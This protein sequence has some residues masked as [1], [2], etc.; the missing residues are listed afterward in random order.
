MVG[1]G[2]KKNVRESYANKVK[3]E[4]TKEGQFRHKLRRTSCSSTSVFTVRI[5]YEHAM[6][7]GQEHGD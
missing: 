5:Q 1:F 7:T 2:T 3:T 4:L 6:Q